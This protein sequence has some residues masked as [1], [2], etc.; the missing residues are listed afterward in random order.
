MHFV[1]GTMMIAVKLGAE[2]RQAEFDDPQW[3]PITA[4]TR[5]SMR[6]FPQTPIKL[7]SANRRHQGRDIVDFEVSFAAEPDPIYN[8][9]LTEVIGTGGSF[10]LPRGK[11][12]GRTLRPFNDDSSSAIYN[13]GR[14]LSRM[15]RNRQERT[16]GSIRTV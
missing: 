16:E 12:Y 15:S 2:Y 13:I 7:T 9:Q 3:T 11:P 10:K 14:I 4:W 8:D 5:I 1:R 6:S